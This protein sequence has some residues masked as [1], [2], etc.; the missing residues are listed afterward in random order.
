M[1]RL[2]ALDQDEQIA[3]NEL[4]MACTQPT[5]YHVTNFSDTNGKWMYVYDSENSA[6]IERILLLGARAGL[7][8]P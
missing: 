8:S 5:P 7:V 2:I 4:A 6:L 1:Q 3:I